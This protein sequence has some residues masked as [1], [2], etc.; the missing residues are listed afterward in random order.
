MRIPT[1][2]FSLRTLFAVTFVGALIA[3]G[4][5]WHSA[6]M[7][8]LKM[9]R[10]HTS[11]SGSTTQSFRRH[12]YIFRAGERIESYEDD[13][14]FGSL[15]KLYRYDTNEVYERDILLYD[16]PFRFPG[17]T[18]IPLTESM[19]ERFLRIERFANQAKLFATRSGGKT[20]LP[21]ELWPLTDDEFEQL[22]R[23]SRIARARHLPLPRNVRD[24]SASSIQRN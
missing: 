2:C 10:L 6:R 8:R 3:C 1:F 21:R 7:D 23:D 16:S 13:F 11:M 15:D 24:D 4:Y 17:S 19:Q 14:P 12:Y 9:P 18:N 22:R 20:M 5:A